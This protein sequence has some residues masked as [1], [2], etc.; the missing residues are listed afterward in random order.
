M[1]PENTLKTTTLIAILLC[2]AACT[3]APKLSLGGQC[4]LTS[5]CEAPLVCR[6]E[7]CRKECESSRDCAVGLRCLRAQDGLGV[8][9]LPEETRC[10]RNSQCPETLVCRMTQCVNECGDDRD[11]PLGATCGEDS[12][13]GMVCVEAAQALCIYDSDCDY[14]LVCNRTT[15][16]CQIE[17]VV[18]EDC[19]AGRTCVPHAGCNDEPCMCRRS[20][21]DGAPCAAGM[22]CVECSGD[23]C[24]TTARYCE[25]PGS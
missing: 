1:T 3:E 12:E 2:A 6:L 23:S 24:A 21:D 9:Q 15:Q 22:D 13:G 4:E 10:E 5:E 7:R 25:R 14:P 8:C 11:C 19:E 20:C 17:C 18:D 16:A